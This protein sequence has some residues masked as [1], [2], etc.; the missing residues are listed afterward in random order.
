MH[1]AK[2]GLP[3]IY[4]IFTRYCRVSLVH[5]IQNSIGVVNFP[6]HSHGQHFWILS[7]SL[8]S[9]GLDLS[10]E[11]I[12]CLKGFNADFLLLGGR[13]L[14]PLYAIALDV[15][16]GTL[17]SF[18]AR[19]HIKGESVY[20]LPL[21]RRPWR[22]QN[23]GFYGGNSIEWSRSLCSII[24]IWIE[25]ILSSAY[26]SILQYIYTYYISIVC[27]V[28]IVYLLFYCPII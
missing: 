15:Q 8:A 16:H 17:K 21:V 4:F 25:L 26:I 12:V 3:D 5:F 19:W 9:C 14:A 13:W 28:C 22:E 6:S 7:I 11:S 27:I 24:L 1:N 2:C 23:L 10:L 20:T 18:S